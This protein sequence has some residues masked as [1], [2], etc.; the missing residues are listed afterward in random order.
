MQKI[1][2]FPQ[3]NCLAVE[4]GRGIPIELTARAGSDSRAG[5]TDSAGQDTTGLKKIG[6]PGL[7]SEL[8]LGSEADQLAT[9]QQV[10]LAGRPARTADCPDSAASNPVDSS[11]LLNIPNCLKQ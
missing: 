6:R 1:P 7:G 5:L 11:L 4:F 3:G 2:S 9:A 8:D 10:A